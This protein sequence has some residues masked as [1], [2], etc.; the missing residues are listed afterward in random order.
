MIPLVNQ[1]NNLNIFV[2]TL[3]SDISTKFGYHMH[4]QIFAGLLKD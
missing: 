1:L 2:Q 4:V 3:S